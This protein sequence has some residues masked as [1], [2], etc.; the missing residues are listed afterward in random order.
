MKK[1]ITI[2]CFFLTF[3]LL[4]VVLGTQTACTKTNTNCT[5]TIIVIDSASKPVNGIAVKLYAPLN[6]TIEANGTTNGAGS[7]SFNFSEPAIFNIK[8]TWAIKA[9]DTLKG[10]GIIQLTGGQT[11]SATVTVER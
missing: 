3:L 6:G 4:F 1:I 10:T 5:A 8:A 9:N 7:V 2:S 11:T